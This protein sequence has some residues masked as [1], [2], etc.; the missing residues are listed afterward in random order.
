MGMFGMFGMFGKKQP[1]SDGEAWFMVASKTASLLEA[2]M[3][4]NPQ[5]LA[6]PYAR[7]MLRDDWSVYAA[8]DKRD[9]AKILGSRD[10]TCYLLREDQQA[11]S[12]W[13]NQLRDSGGG[14]FSQ[15]ATDEFAKHIVHTMR[16][17][18]QIV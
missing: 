7:V 11:L 3:Q 5:M 2:L 13:V 4:S 15:I 8:A 12:I 10:V 16:R 6:D 1:P 14:P 9:P 17:N 18:V